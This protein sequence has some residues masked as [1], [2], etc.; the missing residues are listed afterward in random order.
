MTQSD[1]YSPGVR[2]LYPVQ[3]A[4]EAGRTRRSTEPGLLTPPESTPALISS[5]TFLYPPQ[6]A[7]LN[8][9]VH[10][11]YSP[12]SAASFS[13]PTPHF[14]PM[15]SP[16]MKSGTPSPIIVSDNKAFQNI[17]SYTP[18]TASSPTFNSITLMTSTSQPY[19]N[20][21]SVSD[22]H[23]P[24]AAKL[25]S[26]IRKMKSHAAISMLPGIRASP[27]RKRNS[28]LPTGPLN[29][30]GL[31]VEWSD[32]PPAAAYKGKG[33][34]E[35]DEEVLREQASTLVRLAQSNSPTTSPLQPD[36]FGRRPSVGIFSS[37]PVFITALDGASTSKT[38]HSDHYTASTYSGL[39]K[40]ASSDPI[41]RF[42]SGTLIGS[43][44]VGTTSSHQAKAPTIASQSDVATRDSLAGESEQEHS[45]AEGRLDLS[46]ALGYALPSKVLFFLGFLLGPCE[47]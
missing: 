17:H 3:L 1:R 25:T 46:E 34:Y 44:L 43:T 39:T 10:D 30:L 27:E 5:A 32:M 33:R 2:H 9:Q 20:R 45:T 15:M 12:I 8:P 29:G 6:P 23:L 14:Q 36:F 28:T 35:E 7:H 22:S 47:F 42:R 26:Q 11:V 31:H 40:V 41:T 18:D 19:S 37:R 21:N 13:P 16:G 38:Y 4:E 24:L